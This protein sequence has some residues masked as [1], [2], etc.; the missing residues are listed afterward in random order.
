MQMKN[1][2]ISLTESMAMKGIAIIG[3]LVHHLFY[4]TMEYGALVNHIAWLGKACVAI[5]L[6]LS[7]YGLTYQ[8]M[9]AEDNKTVRG[10]MKF[11]CRR[12][13]KFYLN[14]WIVFLIA[15]PLGVFVFGRTLDVPYGTDN[16]HLLMLLTDF[17]GLNLYESYNITWWF[18]RVIIIFY[19]LF[20]LLFKFTS[21]KPLALLGLPFA[22]LECT[23]CPFYFGIV[24]SRYREDVNRFLNRLPAW[25]IILTSAVMIVV[26]CFV[27]QLSPI[28]Y[29]QGTNI[30]ALT[31]VFL[32]LLIVSWANIRHSEYRVLT[33][34]GKHSMNMYLVHTF[35][36]LYYFGD[37]IYQFKY[38]ILIVLALLITS[39]AVSIAIEQLKKC[40]SF[41]KF[42][43]Y[44]LR[45]IN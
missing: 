10:T 14:Y 2:E 3:M 19:L 13:T 42:L 4:D 12:F 35:I 5:F 16:N 18:N 40:I 44:L 21:Y 32:S 26:L 30:D 11:L 6:F 25:S 37:F 20:P 43:D 31:T 28:P 38:P 45:K 29:L 24:A 7:G 27:R 41:Y 39:L 9:R 15:V 34:L 1:Y 33:Y 17:L 22:Y 8:Y 23:F 36:F